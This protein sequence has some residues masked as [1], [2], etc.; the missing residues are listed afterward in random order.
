MKRNVIFCFSGTGNCLDMARNIARGL[1]NTDIIM[2]RSAPVI[3][4][5]RKAER[6]GFVFPCYGGGAPADV[7]AFARTIRVSPTAY[8]FGVSSSAS[9]AG[10]GLYE[11]DKIIPLHYWRTVTHHC[12]C[13]WLFPH[14]V[15]KP[16]MSLE[17]AQQRSEKLA[18]EIAYDVATGKCSDKRPPHNLLNAAEN[19]GFAA[20]LSKKAAGFRVSDACVG[21]GQCVRLCPRNNIRLEHGKAVIGTNCAQCLGCLQFCPKEAISL[22]RITE[23]R[24]HYHNPKV[25]AEDLMQTVIEIK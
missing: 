7:L 17:K 18:Q 23:K 24:E 2:M 22:G 15:M 3:T 13:I 9:Y 12:S 4:D 16:P 6:V 21:C 10:T 25:S 1:G 19:K 20:M 5:V 11:L 8:T 14:Q